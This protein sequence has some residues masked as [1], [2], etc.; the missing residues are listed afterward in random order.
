MS[1][2]SL[3]SL[4]ALVALT[5]CGTRNLT[6]QHNP[7]TQVFTFTGTVPLSNRGNVTHVLA[8][9]EQSAGARRVLTPVASDGSFSL[10]LVSNRPWL[11]TLLD[12]T[13]SGSAM[14]VA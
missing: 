8:V 4:L 5:G 12:G 3:F 1:R 14:T 11:L 2:P 13:R 6:A 7:A 9:N 10:P